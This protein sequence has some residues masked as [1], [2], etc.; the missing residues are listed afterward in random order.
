[1]SRHRR[2][3]AQRKCNTNHKTPSR[4]SRREQA[5]HRRLHTVIAV[6]G[7]VAAVLIAVYAPTGIDPTPIAVAAFEFAKAILMPRHR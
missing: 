5:S 7:I 2:R 4:G 1:M 3:N 6:A